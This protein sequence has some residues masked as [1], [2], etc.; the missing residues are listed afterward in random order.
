MVLAGLMIGRRA[1]WLMYA[2]VLAA[3]V[4]GGL[5]DAGRG[6]PIDT[7]MNVAISVLTGAVIHLLI[8]IRRRSQRARVA[9][10]PGRRD[11]GAATRWRRRTGACRRRWPSARGCS[12]S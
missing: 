12:S 3:F 7:P 11:R 4:A 9:R 5:V 2:C 10:E 8:A 6:N 1:L